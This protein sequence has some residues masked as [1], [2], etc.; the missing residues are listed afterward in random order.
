MTVAV[1]H[2]AKR[3]MRCRVRELRLTRR[4]T[5][6]K[7]RKEITAWMENTVTT[8]ISCKREASITAVN[9]TAVR[10]STPANQT[11]E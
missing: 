8:S 4:A 6:G 5:S 2:I 11:Y 10:E 3:R 7:I 9:M 1:S